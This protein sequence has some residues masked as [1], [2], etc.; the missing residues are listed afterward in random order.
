MKKK[1]QKIKDIILGRV[2][3]KSEEKE[4]ENALFIMGLIGLSVKALSNK[5]VV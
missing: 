4:K 3:K 1:Q 2:N 5:N